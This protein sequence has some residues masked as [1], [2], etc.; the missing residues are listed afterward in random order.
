MCSILDGKN[1]LSE[2]MVNIRADQFVEM[3]LGFGSK[4]KQ[5]FVAGAN[6]VLNTLRLN[7]VI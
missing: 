4:H 6:Y 5:S 2:E 1:P 7:N 3:H